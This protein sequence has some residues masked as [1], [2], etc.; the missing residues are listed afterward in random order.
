VTLVTDPSRVPVAEDYGVQG[1]SVTF[2]IGA[3]A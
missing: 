3:L 2:F 1:L